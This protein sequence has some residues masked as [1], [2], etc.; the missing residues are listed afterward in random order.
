MC[1]QGAAVAHFDRYEI[2]GHTYQVRNP[3]LTLHTHTHA[4]THTHTGQS[5]L[6][7]LV[8]TG[9]IMC[10]CVCVSSQ[11]GDAVYVVRTEDVDELPEEDAG[12]CVCV[13]VCV[14]E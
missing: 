13:C 7:H 14:R 5:A 3:E 10:V 12:V 8:T 11:I 2:D 1:L 6:R 9:K 4:H